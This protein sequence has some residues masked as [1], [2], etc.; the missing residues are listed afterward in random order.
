MTQPIKELDPLYRLWKDMRQRCNNPNNQEFHNYGG[1]GIKICPEWD[2]FWIFKMDMGPRPQG[3]R[4][5]RKNNDLGYSKENCRW[6]TP[7]EQA[8]N[9]R[10][11][12][13]LTHNGKTQ[14]VLDWSKELGIGNT[15]LLLRLKTQPLEVAL[16]PGRRSRNAAWLD[17]TAF[18]SRH[19]KPNENPPA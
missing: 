11:T 12:R 3:Y 7:R 14:C 16:T 13:M 8:L 10:R 17:R 1:R 18:L 4:L 6:A 15:A 9:T 2:D 19:R 5:D